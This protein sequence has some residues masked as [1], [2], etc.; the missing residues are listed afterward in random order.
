MEENRYLEDVKKSST[1]VDSQYCDVVDG[2]I[3]SGSC[4]QFFAEQLAA[5]TL[6]LEGVH[7]VSIVVYT[8]H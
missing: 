5:V 8:V 6:N 2:V 1:I 7:V 4:D 3:C